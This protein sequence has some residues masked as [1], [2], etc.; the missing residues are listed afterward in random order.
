MKEFKIALTSNCEDTEEIIGQLGEM[1]VMIDYYKSYINNIESRYN[2]VHIMNEISMPI[3]FTSGLIT[4][5]GIYNL[6]A[7]NG[8]KDLGKVLTITG[9]SCFIGFELTYQLGH[10]AFKFW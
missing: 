7:D 8:N 2:R 5:I 6:V 1:Q 10:F 4:G 9:A 3:L